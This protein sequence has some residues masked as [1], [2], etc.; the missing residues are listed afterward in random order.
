VNPIL[1][2]R[3]C[4][5]TGK[6]VL[7][8]IA[9]L[10]FFW[11]AV[12]RAPALAQ[13]SIVEATINVSSQFSSSIG[14]G[15]RALAMGGA[16][17]AVADDGTAASWNPAG[18]CVLERPE[19][20]L[21]WQGVSELQTVLSGTTSDETFVADTFESRS[22]TRN[23]D[24]VF[25]ESGRPFDF[26]SFAYPVRQGRWK[27]VPQ[28][29]FQRA[30][31]FSLTS[32][33]DPVSFESAEA[34]VEEVSGEITTSESELFAV[35][36]LGGRSSGGIDIYAASLG[37][38]FRED[39]YFGVSLN[40][41]RGETEAVQTV[42]FEVEGHQAFTGVEDSRFTLGLASS[43]SSTETR[44]GFN[45]S[46]GVLW[47]PTSK[48]RLGGVFKTPFDLE[49]KAE[50][51]FVSSAKFSPLIA[52]D[53]PG[54]L[55]PVLISSTE[56]TE[57][58]TVEWPSTIGLGASFSPTD[59]L[60]LSTDF[61]WSGWSDV[62]YQASSR[63][64][65]VPPTGSDRDLCASRGGDFSIGENGQGFC[66]IAIRTLWP[67][68]ADPDLPESDTNLRQVDTQQFRFGAE[69]LIVGPSF[70]GLTALPLRAGA[71]TD[72]QY[73]QQTN[74]T[75]V[76]FVG[77]TAGF[78]LVWPHLSFDVAYV[79]KTGNYRNRDFFL[80]EPPEFLSISI[81]DED[82]TFSSNQLYLSGIVR[83]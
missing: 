33:A 73:F 66:E 45:T 27:L 41:W 44:R 75:P 34:S 39:L 18:L 49:R 15:A 4:R 29:S 80:A 5:R 1:N 83:F 47:K 61:T 8:L 17:I 52:P 54:E 38:S 77:I 51:S 67:T 59:S 32:S 26:V 6:P 7:E 71:F 35:G 25:E 9:L 10:S 50:T 60:T 21:V 46:F 48:L 62:I 37:V 22:H 16:F 19:S 78:G 12:D 11:C 53:S 82:D 74:R 28:F 55:T 2:T 30:V 72:R 58:G 40:W 65:N 69:Y 3:S 79:H 20:S 64:T 13:T 31:S 76:T 57:G 14:S 81:A 23:D 42:R 56:S 68:G 70:G 63:D 24:L 36:A 43:L